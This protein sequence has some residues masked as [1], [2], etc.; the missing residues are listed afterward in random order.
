MPEKRSHEQ[1][2]QREETGKRC[3]VQGVEALVVLVLLRDD[4]PER[5][6]R[7]EIEREL[8]DALPEHI[9]QALK[10]L[11]SRGVI[12]QQEDQVWASRCARHLD[13][14]CLIAI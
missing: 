11:V 12:G 1:H 2:Q 14:L 6:S 8:S 10:G 3:E 13:T 4:H 7:A 9:G 5:W